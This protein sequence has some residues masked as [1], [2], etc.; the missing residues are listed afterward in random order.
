MATLLL[1]KISFHQNYKLT[2]PINNFINTRIVAQIK[3]E[4]KLQSSTKPMPYFYKIKLANIFNYI[5]I[6]P[7]KS[8]TFYLNEQRLVFIF[9][10]QLQQIDELKRFDIRLN[11]RNDTNKIIYNTKINIL[12]TMIS[13]NKYYSFNA[14]NIELLFLNESHP[15]QNLRYQLIVDNQTSANF[16][17]NL[18]ENNKSTTSNK[19]T[20]RLIKCMYLSTNVADSEFILDL[21]GRSN[22][23]SVYICVFESDFEFRALLTRYK[24]VKVIV[25]ASVPNA[26]IGLP[27]FKRFQ[28]AQNYYSH[29]QH[30]LGVMFDPVLEFTLNLIYPLLIA[31]GQYSYIH[32]GDFDHLLLKA[33]NSIQNQSM[34]DYI[35][36]IVRTNRINDC[37]SLYFNQ[38]WAIENWQSKEIFRDIENIE[39]VDVLNKTEAIG[40]IGKCLF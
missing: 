30:D 17:V 34:I 39:A 9:L 27:S 14:M 19:T 18:V 11:I 38:Y 12:A 21:I 8:A 25:L 1:I 15:Q 37:A 31:Q 3:N 35:H 13:S 7:N 40:H 2:L 22:Y 10:L 29:F 16:N 36:D 26:I 24:W 20:A 4:I 23:D 33:S 32:A 5:F 6:D 28:D